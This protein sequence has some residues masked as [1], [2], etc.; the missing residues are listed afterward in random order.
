MFSD[1]SGMLA[2]GAGGRADNVWQRQLLNLVIRG[3]RRQVKAPL[4]GP[5]KYHLTA[6]RLLAML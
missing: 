3:N 2:F 6:K 1:I 4:C 5:R